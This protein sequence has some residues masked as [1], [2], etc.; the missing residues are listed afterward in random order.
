MYANV[1]QVIQLDKLITLIKLICIIL[2]NCLYLPKFS[3][4]CNLKTSSIPLQQVEITAVGV[5]I[6]W[7]LLNCLMT[8]SRH[9]KSKQNDY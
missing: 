5:R 1:K 3:G 8:I 4:P 9:S 2:L 7:C 6:N